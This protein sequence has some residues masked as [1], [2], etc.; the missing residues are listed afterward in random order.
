VTTTSNPVCALLTLADILQRDC[1]ELLLLSPE[2]LEDRVNRQAELLRVCE[3][4]LSHP[5]SISPSD[6]RQL[7]SLA[8]TLLR[9]VR[10]YGIVLRAGIRSNA[11]LLRTLCDLPDHATTLTGA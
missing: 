3:A 6:R 9:S 2:Q 8:L 1:G 4:S 11:A 7:R 10:V 5:E